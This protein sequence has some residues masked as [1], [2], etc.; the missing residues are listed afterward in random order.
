MRVTGVIN[1]DNGDSYNTESINGK[2]EGLG[3]HSYENGN[4]YDGRWMND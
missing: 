1:Y 2:R 3:V 4:V